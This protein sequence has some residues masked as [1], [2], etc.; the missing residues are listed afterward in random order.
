MK[1]TENTQQTLKIK[2]YNIQAEKNVFTRTNIFM[3]KQFIVESLIII[4][5]ALSRLL[6]TLTSAMRLRLFFDCNL[7]KMISLS[8]SYI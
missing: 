6:L 8:Q 7:K 2:R 3:S 5:C 4:F 1:S